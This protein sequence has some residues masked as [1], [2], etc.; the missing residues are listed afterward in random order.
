MPVIV[1]HRLP[2]LPAIANGGTL[3]GGSVNTNFNHNKIVFF[4]FFDQYQ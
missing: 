1:V 3:N 2:F 4:F